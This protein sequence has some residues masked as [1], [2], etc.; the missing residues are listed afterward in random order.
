MIVA[1]SLPILTDA[2]V[3]RLVQSNVP[4]LIGPRS[5]SKT[6]NFAIPAELP[7]GP[8]QRAIPI[9][10]TR[11]E[12]LRPGLSK[13]ENDEDISRWFEHVETALT[14]D[15]ELDD[16]T[17]MVFRSKNVRYLAAWPG[18][19]FLRDLLRKM[20]GDAKLDF[21]V[22]PQDIRIRTAGGNRY[23]FNYGRESISLSDIFSKAENFE[24]ILGSNEIDSA[25]VS[26]WTA[27]G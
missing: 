14:P 27:S 10:V 9:K 4:V 15:I 1:P 22:L 26:A 18:S 7:P 13:G 19:D 3:K 17:A 24:F 25:G 21:V 12:S 11:V 5:G 8:L 6:V 23:A 16:G 2:L 20:A